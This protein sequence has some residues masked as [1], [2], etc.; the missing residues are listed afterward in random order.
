M[1]VKPF[2][3]F[4]LIA[5]TLSAWASDWGADVSLPVLGSILE[6]DI[7]EKQSEYL[8]ESDSHKAIA[9]MD[10]NVFYVGQF[11]NKGLSVIIKNAHRAA[12]ISGLDRVNVEKNQYV[13]KQDSI[14]SV[15]YHSQISFVMQTL[16]RIV[17]KNT[18][19]PADKFQSDLFDF[20]QTDGAKKAAP[21]GHKK[22]T[23]LV[24]RTLDYGTIKS[25]LMEVGFEERTIPTMYCIAKLES[26]LNPKAL[27]FNDNSTVDVG[28][29]QINSTWL[30]KCNT[31]ISK[32]YNEKENTKCAYTVFQIQGFPA[33]TTYNTKIKNSSY[34][35]I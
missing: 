24:K 16:K 25:L 34:C 11:Q 26:A 20:A 27:N 35:P 21:Q 17:H 22:Q 2:A 32:L 28:L 8:I 15:A 14:G 3:L 29:F 18:L 19:N 31:T 7:S 6:Q 30:K 13:L 9:P 10:G 12:I 1:N 5:S 4:S 23:L 33:W